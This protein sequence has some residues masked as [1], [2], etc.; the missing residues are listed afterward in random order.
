MNLSISE[1]ALSAIIGDSLE[2]ARVNLPLS[3]HVVAVLHRLG[4]D[5]DGDD[6]VFVTVILGNDVPEHKINWRTL[7]PISIA[8]SEAV[9]KPQPQSELNAI[10]YVEFLTEAEALERKKERGE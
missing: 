6:A 10:P 3:P 4:R 9:R 5:H 8:M 2:R 1:D 7:E